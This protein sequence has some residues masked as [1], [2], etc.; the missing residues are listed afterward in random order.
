MVDC[1]ILDGAQISFTNRRLDWE[2]EV[3]PL[4]QLL[5]IWVLLNSVVERIDLHPYLY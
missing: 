4:Q 3:Q 1:F 5:S 2:Y